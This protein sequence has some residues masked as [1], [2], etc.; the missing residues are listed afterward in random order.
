[1]TMHYIKKLIILLLVVAFFS[2][3]D[4]FLKR[5]ELDIKY[6]EKTPVESIRIDSLNGNIEIIGWSKDFI[7]IN[8]K[9]KI[10]SGLPTDVNLIDTVFFLDEEYNE[11][12]IKTKIPARINARIDLK[13]YIPFILLKIYLNSQRGNININKFLGDLELVCSNGVSS[14]DFQG[15]ILRINS[16]KSKINLNLSSYN[17]CDI[18]LNNEDGEINSFIYTI[19]NNS[20]LD[21]KSLNTNVSL[22]IS[23]EI[24]HKLMIKNRNKGINIKY[25]L[26]NYQTLEGTYTSVS[27]NYG[28]NYNGLTIDIN[29]ENGKTN[30][31]QIKLTLPGEY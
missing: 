2:C 22:F 3:S 5:K 7:E 24:D 14:I 30:L 4:N 9:K 6:R 21:I 25:K 18:I 10:I 12:N 27:G 1:M 20:Y 16:Y 11:L 17:S 19:G 13:I 28:K 23:E 31:Q 29:N 8:T 15:N 26:D